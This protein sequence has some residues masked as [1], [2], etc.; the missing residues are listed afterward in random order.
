MSGNVKENNE[1]KQRLAEEGILPTNLRIEKDNEMVD[2]L[3]YPYAVVQFGTRKH[4]VNLL[5]SQGI[6]IANEEVLNNS[7]SLLEYKLA[8]AIQKVRKREKANILFTEGRGELNIRQTADLKLQSY[9]PVQK[10]L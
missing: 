6:A 10:Y 9:I 3:I 2:K 4:I 5:E 7:V 1:T 8:D